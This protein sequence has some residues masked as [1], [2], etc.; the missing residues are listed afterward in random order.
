MNETYRFKG[1]MDLQKT[2]I[3][4]SSKIIYSNTFSGKKSV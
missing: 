3:E 2:E 4:Y 1:N